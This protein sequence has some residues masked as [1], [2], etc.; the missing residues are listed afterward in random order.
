MLDWSAD[1]QEF[2]SGMKL[3]RVTILGTSGGG[4]FAVACAYGLPRSML[5]DVGLFASG[6]PW[7]AGRKYMTYT[8]RITSF[9]AHYSPTLLTIV[10]DAVLAMTRWVLSTDIATRKL[11]AWLELINKKEADKR[12]EQGKPP[13]E[14]ESQSLTEQKEYLLD[15]LIGEPFVQGT[16][17]MVLEAKLLSASDWG[18]PL[19]DVTYPVKIW[20][21][22]KDVN[23]PIE[24]MRYLAGK[25][26]N[27]TL[28]E[29]DKDTHYTMG[30]HLDFVLREVMAVEEP[31][32]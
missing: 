30:N 8:R 32:K 4:P 2:A 3:D 25:M 17:A 13:K 18:F 31:D 12:R 26:P 22:A 27:A 16:S 15:L 19:E 28:H 9:M 6:P 21:G 11:E 23:S 14:D 5:A 20:H 1:V 24:A 29:F 10:M 7:A